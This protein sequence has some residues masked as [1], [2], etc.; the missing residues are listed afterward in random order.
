VCE[1]SDGQVA[2]AGQPLGHQTQDYALSSARVTA[3][4]GEAAFTY[5]AVLN[6]P[7]ETINLAS[8]PQGLGGQLW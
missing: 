4:K 8:Y 5:Q 1:D 2:G 3:D 7:T 6:T